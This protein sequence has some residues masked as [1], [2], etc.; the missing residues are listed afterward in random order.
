VDARSPTPS[1]NEPGPPDF[2]A[3]ELDAFDLDAFDLDTLG[4]E[5]WR[6]LAVHSPEATLVS[7]GRLRC[8]FASDAVTPLTGY[9]M[10]AIL[11]ADLSR[12][13]HWEDLAAIV[14]LFRRNPSA[15]EEGGAF[16]IRVVFSDGVFHTVNVNARAL[17]V[18][19]RSCVVMT[20]R[21]VTLDRINAAILS[22]KIEMERILDR[23]QRGF[24]MT[25]GD[26]IELAIHEALGDV[27]RS[28]EADRSYLLDYDFEART[29]S[30]THEWC[31]PDMQPTM[32]RHQQVSFDL[33]PASTERALA[34]EILA[35]P[36]VELLDGI[37]ADDREFYEAEGL[38]AVLE[39]PITIDGV[40]TGNLGLEWC[41]RSATWTSDDLGVLGMFASSFA[42]ILARRQADRARAEL[43]NELRMGFEASPVPLAL[44]D[45]VGT[46]LQV[47]A[48]LCHVLGRGPD[49]LN[50]LVAL[51]IVDPLF[52]H[53]CVQWVVDAMS[54]VDD[55]LPILRAKL[56]PAD[57]RELW[58]DI[59]PR[60][61]RDT[62]GAIVN[63]VI[64]VLDVTEQLRAARALAES[65]LRFSTL[66][67]NLP[68]PVMRLDRDGKAQFAN[69]A[70]A[71]LLIPSNDD[72]FEVTDE[73]R[74]LLSTARSTAFLT[75]A[76][77]SVAYEVHTARGPRF[78]ET[79]LVP[80]PSGESILLVSTDL[81]E[82]RRSE[83]E[84]AYRAS[85][86]G[87]T[88]LP[89]RS[90]FLSHLH[91]SLDRLERRTYGLVAVLFFDL[92]RFK[93]VNDS[94]GHAAGDDLL[95]AMARRLRETV[96]PDDVV[97]RL[98]GDEFTVLLTTCE[99]ELQVRST[100][101]RLQQALAQPV[102]IGGREMVFT[103]SVGAS[104]AVTGKE[105]PE[106]L[107]QW[108]DA[109]MYRAKEAGRD[110]VV[111]FDDALAASVRH[112]LELD[113][114]LRHALEH[115]E[116][117]VW[118]QPEVDLSTG[119]ILGA[120]A[121]VRWR[122]NGEVRAAADFIEMAE[123]TGLIVPLGWWVLD[124]AC[125][126]AAA[127][128]GTAQLPEGIK[129]RVNLSARQI[130]QPDLVP[131]V[132]GA[133]SRSGLP[134]NRLCLEITE[135]ALMADAQRSA[136]LLRE[137]DRLG[138]ELAVDDFGTG[139]SSLAYL[140]QF[141]VDV[142]KIDRSFIDGLPNDS[143]DAA[144]VATI[145]RLAESLGMTVTAEGIEGQSQ[146]DA[147]VEMGCTRGQGYHFA[148]PMPLEQFLD[149][150][151]P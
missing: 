45:T 89:N 47:N 68:D 116:F 139:Y 17:E 84:L 127:W 119:A 39:L 78:L 95:R 11:G 143:D 123:E 49:E 10:S 100:A 62:S 103:S 71:R 149:Q 28:L 73:V 16:D 105:S 150:L 41:T 142:L 74:Q 106:E 117:E 128:P 15:L 63:F 44:I 134:A 57:G 92:D 133:L 87:L 43:T 24:I 144:I 97:A 30:L 114:E 101:V 13:V 76:T 52:H 66:V 34:G 145:I 48:E 104:I 65:E 31:G 72:H 129:V 135:T 124:A 70:A 102:E 80:E 27:G 61:V 18:S 46:M 79:R 136:E 67:N 29:E 59:D 4:A 112:R 96:R 91:I 121:L 33:T 140:K 108:A 113:Q 85:H 93:V 141:P 54:S 55:Q 132:S 35:I 130:D 69:K 37:W 77:Q 83:N 99:S 82:R 118:Y 138:V 26:D 146:A 125:H 147:L 8:I 22:R 20:A 110:R 14:D 120:E 94:L 81:T 9:A 90:L 1:S 60:P 3:F 98:G 7:D 50:G 151:G 56:I 109:A 58:A 2:D 42:Q 53:D 122:A 131:R 38:R 148:R 19:G 126:E 25:S 23:V 12:V 51:E 107:M 6:S 111:L 21:E 115:G 36:S 86:D 40:V 5:V 32:Q 137:L 88:D 75:G 64:Q